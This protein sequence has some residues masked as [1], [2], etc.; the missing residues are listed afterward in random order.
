MIN[1][2]TAIALN[3]IDNAVYSGTTSGTKAELLAEISDRTNWTGTIIGRKPQCL[4]ATLAQLHFKKEPMN[5][6]L[7]K[8]KSIN[9]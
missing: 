6:S 9:Q 7:L 2:Q 5:I 1:G 4:A 8:S 3:E